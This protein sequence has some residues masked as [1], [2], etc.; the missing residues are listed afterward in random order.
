MAEIMS[1]FVKNEDTNTMMQLT[2]FTPRNIKKL[3]ENGYTFVAHAT[4]GT[5]WDVSPDEIITPDFD[6]ETALP[7]ITYQLWTEVMEPL[8]AMMASSMQPAVALMPMSI[9]SNINEDYN[10]FITA[11][12][13]IDGLLGALPDD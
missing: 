13:K 3:S 11:L 5:E 8:K 7:F 1:Y 6:K 12:E 10:N 9:R 2:D 4:D